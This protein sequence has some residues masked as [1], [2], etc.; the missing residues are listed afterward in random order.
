MPERAAGGDGGVFV[1]GLVGRAGSGKSTVARALVAAGAAVIEADR[2]GHEITD[3]DPEVRAALTAAYGPDA[4]GADGTLDRARVAA[5]VFA[6]PA[7]LAELNA[8]VHPRIVGRIRAA[9]AAYRAAGAPAS[10]VVDAAL[11]LDWGLD[12]DCDAVLAIVAPQALQLARLSASRGWNESEA[13]ARLRAQRANEAFEA[14]ADA[15]IH[16][17]GT[18]EELERAAHEALARLRSARMRRSPHTPS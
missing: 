17:T 10:V 3:H 2:I 4:Y 12:R 6:D 9:L 7:A 16:N 5:R 15:V 8:L 11:M 14:A 18:R 1:L 13:R